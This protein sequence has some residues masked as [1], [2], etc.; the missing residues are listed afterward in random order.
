MLFRSAEAGH[1]ANAMPSIKALS[2]PSAAQFDLQSTEFG[3]TADILHAPMPDLH[4]PLDGT[5][6][7]VGDQ[8]ESYA[9]EHQKIGDAGDEAR[10]DDLEKKLAENAGD[11]DMHRSLFQKLIESIEK[12]KEM[13]MKAVDEST[14]PKHSLSRYNTKYKQGK[15]SNLKKKSGRA[16]ID[17]DN[18][19]EDAPEPHKPEPVVF[20]I[21]DRDQS[22]APSLKT[23]VK[24]VRFD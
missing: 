20:T 8:G 4:N 18:I 10:L 5:N 11:A 24:G 9:E 19:I 6:Q 3:G 16:E 21:P 17:T 14:L 2:E 13:Q 7:L 12:R 23:G 22:S 1:G 15:K